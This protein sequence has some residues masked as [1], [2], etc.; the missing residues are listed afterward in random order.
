MPPRIDS[1]E[2]PVIVSY[3]L[4]PSQKDW[5]EKRATALSQAN[6][7]HISA[8]TIVRYLIDNYRKSITQ[9]ATRGP[10]VDEPN[11]EA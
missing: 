5:L 4:L 10:L 7:M 9:D 3:T 1:T 2:R 6:D 8:S 11:K